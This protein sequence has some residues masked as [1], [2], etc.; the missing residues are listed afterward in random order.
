MTSVCIFEDEK[1]QQLQPLTYFRPSYHLKC[2]ILSL[3][4]K[5]RRNYPGIRVE[6]NIRS[7]LRNLIKQ[8]Y[9]EEIVEHVKSD[10]MLFLNGRILV[11]DHFHESVPL[12]GPDEVFTCNGE[13]IGARVSGK[14]LDS[15]SSSLKDVLSI[16]DFPNLP[17]REIEVTIINYPWDLVKFNE[18]ELK[19][20]FRK[21][22]SQNDNQIREYMGVYFLNEADIFIGKNV[23]I[24]PGC[25]LDAEEGPIY[26]GDNVQIMHNASILGPT[27]I[28]QM[29]VTPSRSRPVMQAVKWRLRCVL[30]P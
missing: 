5:I 9:P 6:L 17:Q 21:L 29:R 3:H 27:F 4:R 1:Y 8:N 19:S 16:N 28:G 20:D 11:D 25:V 10:N 12:N 18:R 24:K 7:Y 14:N 15:V 13:F 23:S 30:T 22:T 26:I 2:G